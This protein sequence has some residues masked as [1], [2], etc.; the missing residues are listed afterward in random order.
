[1]TQSPLLF[2]NWESG[3][4][5]EHPARIQGLEGEGRQVGPA[6][7]K[8]DSVL[9]AIS[10]AKHIGKKIGLITSRMEFLWMSS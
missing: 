2:S 6:M 3:K 10:R 9:Q 8:Y 4:V 1:M 7:A 5:S